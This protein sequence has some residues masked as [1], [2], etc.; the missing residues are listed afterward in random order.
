M[1]HICCLTK[2]LLRFATPRRDRGDCEVSEAVRYGKAQRRCGYLHRNGTVPGRAAV[3]T[4]DYQA[5]WTCCITL[6]S[7]SEN[8]QSMFASDFPVCRILSRR[9][10]S[11]FGRRSTLYCFN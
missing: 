8:R 9:D 5:V 2:H 1:Q 10:G 3:R 7:E 11:A 6:I 4:G